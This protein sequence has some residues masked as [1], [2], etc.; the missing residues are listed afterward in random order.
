MNKI[1]LG[2]SLLLITV[3][4]LAGN[5]IWN[6]LFNEK[7]EEAN[8][9]ESD[10]QYDVGTMYQN[11]RGVAADR[12]KAV[13]WYKQA[14]EQG[15]QKAVSRL[16][17]MESN[18]SRFG[19]TLS[20]AE[21]GNG[22]SQYEIGNMFMTGI[23]ADIDYG[24]AL[25]FYEKSAAQGYNKAAYKL[26][27][28]YYEGTGVSTNKKTA[29]KW[30]S[31]AAENNYAVAQYYLGKLYAAGQGTKRNNK[32]ALEWLTKAVDGGF[33]QARGELIN[34]QEKMS[35]E[36]AAASAKKKAAEKK[37]AA[38]ARAE[39]EAKAKAEK[40]A[41]SKAART[42]SEKTAASKS[43][44]A[45]ARKAAKA[46]AEKAAAR[47]TAKAKAAE[48]EARKGALEIVATGAWSR[49]NKPITYLPSSINTCRTEDSKLICFSDDQTRETG[50]NIIK[51]K[52]KAIIDNFSDKDKTFRVTYRN[53]VID[54]TPVTG[55]D[56]A[57]GDEEVEGG[58][59]VKTGWGSP[60]TMACNFKDN[61][62]VSCLKNNTHAL[63][64]VNSMAVATSGR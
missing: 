44:K 15:N 11:G 24:K 31:S 17:L 46:K 23:G 43:E 49:N 27:L 22:K 40:A 14:A 20:A 60:H 42:K 45:A 2:I 30:F 28:I 63:L 16:K 21:S 48:K 29:F 59:K 34:V 37:A 52:T 58:F 19:K 47:K 57:A 41:A 64:L 62:A 10:A 33:D 51:F 3:T 8:S 50:G 55:T 36:S 12:N 25:S 56:L 6:A 38:V 1:V 9:G 13:E 4:S 53:L 39:Q 54:A 5:D 18:A 61:G 26:G 35:M 7:L 32:L